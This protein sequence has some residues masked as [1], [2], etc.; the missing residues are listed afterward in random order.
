MHMSTTIGEHALKQHVRPSL[1]V[2]LSL[3]VFSPVS[4]CYMPMHVV[5]MHHATKGPVSGVL[6]LSMH[7]SEHTIPAARWLLPC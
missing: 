6:L 7:R 5:A 3:V 1:S 4:N 2:R